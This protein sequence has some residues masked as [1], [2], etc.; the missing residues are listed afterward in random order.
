LRRITRSVRLINM[1]VIWYTF[2]N[3]FCLMLTISSAQATPETP[4]ARHLR[5]RIE[6]LKAVAAEKA[7]L[8]SQIPASEQKL[9]KESGPSKPPL[10]VDL[11]TEDDGDID[12]KEPDS[13]NGRSDKKNP[14][15]EGAP[16]ASP[17][18]PKIPGKKPPP[19]AA[20]QDPPRGTGNALPVR[21]GT[22]LPP[23]VFPSN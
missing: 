2:L 20:P 1:Q 19:V 23:I 10:Q 5:L 8:D 7:A 12:E 13:K 18:I 17:S 22:A 4:E 16:L 6:Q 14:P 11:R 15:D 3:L 21:P 9:S